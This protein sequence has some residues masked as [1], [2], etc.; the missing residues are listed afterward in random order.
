M[1]K[2]A[3]D[4]AVEWS[5]KRDGDSIAERVTA[6]D[7][8]ENALKA[9]QAME[10][11]NK[12]VAKSLVQVAT[13]KAQLEI[14]QRIHDKYGITIQNKAGVNA[15]KGQYTRVDATVLNSLEIR[16]WTTQELIM[17]EQALSKYAGLLGPERTKKGLAPQ[18]ITTFSRLKQG[19]DKNART[20]ELDT[21]TCGETFKNAKNISM[22]D[23]GT[24]VSDFAK[25]KL[26]P[27]KK[28][29]EKGFRGT[30]EH[31]LSHAVIEK[32]EVETAKEALPTFTTAM[33]DFWTDAVTA[34]YASR[35]EARKK[36]IEAPITDYG[37]TLAQEDLA[38]AMMFFFEDPKKLKSQCPKRFK[39][40]E[41]KVAPHLETTPD[42]S[43]IV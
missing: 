7:N 38:E 26:F 25:F 30:I 2:R 15:I 12:L 14:I 36:G 43:V 18:G 3:G 21:T 35:S 5:A 19:I 23:A 33:S 22:F 40:I 28:A 27:T 6:L 11:K 24:S 17:V 4:A 37:A 9:Q 32:L 29:K 20:G 10:P 16:E 13:W 42:A 34:K 39:F 1:R 31:E 8:L 41:E